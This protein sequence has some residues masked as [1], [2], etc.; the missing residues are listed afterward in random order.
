MAAVYGAAAEVM[1]GVTAGSGL[2]Y[3]A[4]VWIGAD[5]AFTPLLGLS[6]RPVEYP[7]STHAYALSSH[8]VYGVTTEVIRRAVRRLL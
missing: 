3:G 5:E 6:K 2:A 8:L 4:A 7:V 1:P